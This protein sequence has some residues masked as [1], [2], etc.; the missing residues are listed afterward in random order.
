MDEQILDEL[1]DELLPS[2]ETL[3]TQSGAVLQFLKDKGIATEEQLAPYLEQAKNASDVRWRAV[4]LRTK[5]LLMA[6]IEKGEKHHEEKSAAGQQKSSEPQNPKTTE[7]EEPRRD[8]T[9][10]ASMK[11]S[12][13]ENKPATEEQK[14]SKEENP[15]HKHEQTKKDAA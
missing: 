14:N 11:A 6:A 9:E 12:S 15:V 2:F 1:L 4:R 8:G 7:K 3:E 13:S 10:H 5:R